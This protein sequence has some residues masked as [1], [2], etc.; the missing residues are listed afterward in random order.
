LR[1]HSTTTIGSE[2]ALV[3]GGC[4]KT[5]LSG[6]LGGCVRSAS[7]SATVTYLGGHVAPAFQGR[8]RFPL[9]MEASITPT[10]SPDIAVFVHGYWGQDY[11]NSY[12]E[13]SLNVIRIGIQANRGRTEARN[14]VKRGNAT[15]F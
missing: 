4:V 7:L 13:R 9:W 1:L 6:F 2:F 12:Y 14:D 5:F 11:Y 15:P 8:G 3:P 10:F